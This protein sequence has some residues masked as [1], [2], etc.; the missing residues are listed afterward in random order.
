MKQ[1]RVGDR[2]SS[3]LNRAR[4]VTN[5]ARMRIV[6]ATEQAF[7]LRNGG[8]WLILPEIERE[9]GLNTEFAHQLWESG[10][11]RRLLAAGVDG[12]LLT[13]VCTTFR[14]IE[15]WRERTITELKHRRHLK[16]GRPPDQFRAFQLCCDLLVNQRPDGRRF[17]A[18]FSELAA[19]IYGRRITAKS[20]CRMLKDGIAA[21]PG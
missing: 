1:I 10:A 18:E 20:Y 4:L 6:G 13:N 17:Y 8:W 21:V 15:N 12:K 16:R 11:N 7:V 9:A 19:I 14:A 5:M 3:K 2:L